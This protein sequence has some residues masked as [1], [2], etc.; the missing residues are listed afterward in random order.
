MNGERHSYSVVDAHTHQTVRTVKLRDEPHDVAVTPDGR[1]LYITM[2]HINAVAVHAV[3]D[4][5]EVAFVKQGSRPD[6]IAFTP[7]GA[8]AYVTNRDSREVFVMDA[9]RHANLRRI[10]VG[11]GPHGVLAVPAPPPAPP[12]AKR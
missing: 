10:R 11:N 12:V 6:L 1:F 2:P 4:Q 9:L 7:D 3:A 8:L 5:K